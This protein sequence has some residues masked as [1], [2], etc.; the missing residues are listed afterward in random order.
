[1]SEQAGDTSVYL[2]VTVL[3]KADGLETFVQH[4][5]ELLPHFERVG[6]RLV[7]ACGN[8]TGRQRTIVHVWRIPSADAVLRLERE[9]GALQS[10][11]AINACIED[12]W[13]EIMTALPY[14]K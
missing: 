8:V 13:M 6:W 2:H 3:L 10:F 4:M 1:M 5:A 11:Q 12:E 7:T 14:G 9:L